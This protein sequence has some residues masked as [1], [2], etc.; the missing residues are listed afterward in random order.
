MKIIRVKTIDIALT[1]CALLLIGCVALA[2]F[3][4]YLHRAGDTAPIVHMR[5]AR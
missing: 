1:V 5:P 2:G 4:T 3:T